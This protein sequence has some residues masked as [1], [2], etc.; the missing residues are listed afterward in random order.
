MLASRWE[1]WID[2][3]HCCFCFHSRICK[4][5][6]LGGLLLKQL[7]MVFD[8]APKARC[9]R[10]R[11]WQRRHFLELKFKSEIWKG[12]CWPSFP[13][14]EVWEPLNM[15]VYTYDRVTLVCLYW[16][17]RACAG[18]LASETLKSLR[19]VRLSWVYLNRGFLGRAMHVLRTIFW[20]LLI[21]QK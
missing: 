5:C 13:L 4:W 14:E 19:W 3:C 2:F 8:Q 9:M 16:R 6:L 1:H 7:L 17:D 18:G 10:R 15:R 21:W 20:L 11:T 12:A